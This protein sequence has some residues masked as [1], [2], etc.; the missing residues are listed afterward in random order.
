[1]KL[2]ISFGV[3]NS[4]EKISLDLLGENLLLEGYLQPYYSYPHFNLIIGMT[5]ERGELCL[6]QLRTK[7]K[8]T[9]IHLP[10]LPLK[11]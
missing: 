8:H 5:I 2:V 1:M 6:P 11:V 4:Q 10:L 7:E 9:H 3:V